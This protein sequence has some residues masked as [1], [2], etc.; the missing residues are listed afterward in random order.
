MHDKVTNFCEY[1]KRFWSSQRH[2]SAFSFT[3]MA[4]TIPLK[5][6]QWWCS[7]DS[8]M[9]LQYQIS[10]VQSGQESDVIEQSLQDVYSVERKEFWKTVLLEGSAP[11]VSE[12]V[13]Q[14]KGNFKNLPRQRSRNRNSFFQGR[15]FECNMCTKRFS[16][17]SERIDH[18]L[19]MHRCPFCAKGSEKCAARC[20]CRWIW[21]K[22]LCHGLAS[23]KASRMD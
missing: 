20:V 6:L 12:E 3:R 19:I 23:V 16:M 11:A 15:Q 14:N 7:S 5:R 4:C 8:L 13:V 1:W 10:V 2:S 17:R 22:V 21:A 18:I 9:S